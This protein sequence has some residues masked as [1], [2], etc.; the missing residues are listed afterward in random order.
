M[1]RVLLLDMPLHTPEYPSLA[2]GLLKAGLERSGFPC[3]VL[4]LNLAFMERVCRVQENVVKGVEAFIAYREM[5]AHFI[6][7]ADWLFAADLF[8]QPAEDI[9]HVEEI[10]TCTLEQ[11]HSPWAPPEFD[12]QAMS[13][14]V[15]QMRAQVRPFL[16]DCLAQI[17][18]NAYD[19]IGFTCMYT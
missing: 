16:D 3:D 10:L 14:R 7:L 4:H 11:L 6:L 12:L 5:G 13:T 17:D 9:R 19:I 1:K 2:L 15:V 18:W 8:G